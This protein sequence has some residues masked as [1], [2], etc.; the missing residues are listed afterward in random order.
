MYLHKVLEGLCNYWAARQDRKAAAGKRREKFWSALSYGVLAVMVVLTVYVLVQVRTNGYVSIAGKSLF[1]VVTGSMEPTV[2]TGALLVADKRDIEEIEPGDII[3]FRS[4]DAQTRGWII[5]HRVVD[6]ME[7]D[8]QIC[9][10]TKGDAN[11]V[12]DVS[13]VTGSNLI[14]KVIWYT[15]RDNLFSQIISF[16]TGGT[17]FMA[18]ILFPCLLIAGILLGNSV[19]SIRAEMDLLIREEARLNQEKAQRQEPVQTSVSGGMTE[20]ELA[21]LREQILQ[22]LL[23]DKEALMQEVRKQLAGEVQQGEQDGTDKETETDI[24]RSEE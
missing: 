11:S 19:K 13:Y 1:R 14:G 5:T 22:E 2:P 15:G 10:E 6:R 17:G 16:L 9:L 4:V 3:C 24:D 18:L 12:V 23:K 21:Q 20:E 8:G 7:E